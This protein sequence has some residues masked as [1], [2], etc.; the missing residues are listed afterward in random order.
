M[1]N[2]NPPVK[3]QELTFYMT[4]EDFAN[5]G[6]LKTNPTIATGDFKCSIDGGSFANITAPTI[7]PTGGKGVKVVMT[8]AEMNGDAILL[9]W[10]DQTSPPEWTE[11]S[12]CFLT[13]SA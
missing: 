7:V 3:N 11:S 9:I 13:T 6:Y 8:A 1:A 5:P 12:I 2:S 4:L 10:A